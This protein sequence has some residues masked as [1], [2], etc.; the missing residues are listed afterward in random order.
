MKVTIP[1][2][3]N[4]EPCAVEDV[5]DD[6]VNPMRSAVK[7]AVA[8]RADLT[9]ANLTDANL[10]DADL[11]RADL[12]HANLTHA[13]LTRA[14]L[15]RANLTRAKD[16][17]RAVL[18]AA[19]HEVLG[20]LIA[21]RE[22]RINGSC[23]T[24]TCA[25]LMGTIANLRGYDYRELGDADAL[26]SDNS[27]PAERLFMAISPGH[28]PSINPVAKLVEKWIVEWQAEQRQVLP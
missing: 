3:Y 12:A 19:P 7:Q 16:D 14:D 1:H 10:T 5:P 13:N 23:Y 8:L 15:T 17:F 24:G 11:T 20:L 26:Q 28:I 4:T 25:C 6:S 18:A 9:D 21:I 2:R 22:G 27:R